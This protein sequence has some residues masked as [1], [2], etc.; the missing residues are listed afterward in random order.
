MILLT[1][2]SGINFWLSLANQYI[3]FQNKILFENN[4]I[5]FMLLIHS[6]YWAIIIQNKNFEDHSSSISAKFLRKKLKCEKKITEEEE[7]K[8]IQTSHWINI[9]KKF[10]KLWYFHEI[11]RQNKFCWK[12]PT[13]KI[14]NTQKKGF[15]SSQNLVVK[16]WLSHNYLVTNE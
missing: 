8:M 13:F 11:T 6:S 10:F 4:Q 2:F 9:F 7:R 14:L 5:N 12:I 16:H 1:K 3:I 15:F